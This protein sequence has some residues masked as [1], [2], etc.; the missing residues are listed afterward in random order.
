MLGK[1]RF[2]SHLT[3]THIIN[4]K[5][6]KSRFCICH[7]PTVSLFHTHTTLYSLS[8]PLSHG[9]LLSLC[10]SES[11]AI[12]SSSCYSCCFG[13]T[14]GGVAMQEQANHLQL[15]RFQLGHGW[16]RRRTRLPRQPP[17]RPLLL[18]PIHRPF[19]R[20]TPHPR[21]PLLV[22]FYFPSPFSFFFLIIFLN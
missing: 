14:P 8:L 22:L 13:G 3:V 21:L 19:V 17:Q 2:Y 20:R 5:Q 18:P 6:R 7:W 16:T 15:R 11:F 4:K 10:R 9:L 1:K 12:A